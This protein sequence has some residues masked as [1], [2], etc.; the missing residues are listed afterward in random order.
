MPLT[1]LRLQA[2]L[3]AANVSRDELLQALDEAGALGT[4][5]DPRILNGVFDERVQQRARALGWRPWDDDREA[6]LRGALDETQRLLRDVD[7]LAALV[8]SLLNAPPLKR[9]V[10]TA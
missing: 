5:C 9:E 2:I 7:R 8:G 3:R 4:W 6:V 10:L 1:T